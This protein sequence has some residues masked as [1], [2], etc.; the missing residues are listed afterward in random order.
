MYKHTVVEPSEE[1]RL[2][3]CDLM[4]AVAT[5]L[6]ARNLHT[7][8]LPYLH[9]TIMFLHACAV[10]PYPALRV[11]ALGCLEMLAMQER[12][13]ATFH[14]YCVPLI[15]ALMPG[16]GHRQMKVR[17]A[18][19]K[20]IQEL[21][22]CPHRAKRKGGGS[23]AIVDLV[24]YREE[25]VIPICAFYEGETRI[26]YFG[27]LVTDSAPSVRR[28]FYAMLRRWTT[29]LDDRW[30]HAGR[31]MPF[32]LAGLSDADSVAQEYSLGTLDI[33]GSQYETE[34]PEQ[35][36]EKRQ[37][38]VDG[39]TGRANYEDPWPKPWCRRPRRGTRLYVREH[40]RR[41]LVP[42]LRELGD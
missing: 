19:V 37:Y 22:M 13:C 31:L 21:V 26:N 30:D 29:E 14:H 15:R 6:V 42:V 39:A 24:G 10:D 8:I 11:R 4:C 41:F 23:D 33:L 7:Q 16:L 32:V 34:H 38:A 12:L 20:A 40:A 1:V 35:I 17:T 27:K 3:T 25:N 28:A 18:H 36:I 2:R 9:D 5:S